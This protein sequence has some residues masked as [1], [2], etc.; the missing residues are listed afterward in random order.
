LALIAAGAGAAVDSTAPDWRRWLD[1]V[2]LAPD[3][4]VAA[5]RDAFVRQRDDVRATLWRLLGRLPPRPAVPRVRILGSEEHDTH[6]LERFEFDNEAG[7]TVPGVIFLPKKLA[8]K[9]PA[10]LWNHWHGGDFN[11][12]KQEVFS[13]VKGFIPFAPGPTLAARGYVV[14]TIDSY[15]F[16]ER[17]GHGPGGPEEKDGRGELTA[18][19]FH[20]WAG[21]TLWGMMVRDDQ[22]ALDYLC[23]RPEVDA[24]RIGTTGMSMGATRTWWLMA[25]DER[26]KAA[27]AIC[28][29]TRYR[30]L[31]EDQLLKGHGIYYFVPGMLNHFDSEAV[32]ACI[33]PRAFLSLAGE[34]DP[35]SA[36]RGIRKIEAAAR[37]AWRLFDREDAF[38]SVIQPGVGH[39]YSPEMWSQMVAWFDR[40]L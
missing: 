35:T 4:Q 34:L 11:L 32:I 31:I 2:Q 20:L 33:A 16:G 22:M 5:T 37:P 6:R 8:G 9:A 38:R 39:V 40:H 24:A 14:M 19:K 10:I 26:P 28:C 27:V 7:A 12:G 1:H 13:T 36:V 17:N 21:R 15:C 30:E 23:S 3:F 29:L 18:A 25:L